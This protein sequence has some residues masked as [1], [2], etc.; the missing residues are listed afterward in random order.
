MERPQVSVVIPARNEEEA[1]GPLLDS[2]RAVAGAGAWEIIVVDDGS[3]DR[4]AAIAER[5]GA[6]V[7]RH[8][9]NQGNGASVRRGGCAAGGDVLVFL[10]ADGQHPPE[11]IP[12]L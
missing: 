10:D 11:A 12:R 4:T 6:R 3:T 7:I 1:I 2:I 8:P 9:E 5:H